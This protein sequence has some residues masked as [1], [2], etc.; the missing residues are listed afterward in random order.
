MHDQRA[1]RDRAARILGSWELLAF[2]AASANEVNPPHPDRIVP[3]AGIMVTEE[4]G[5]AR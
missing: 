5:G 1:A 2:Y 3:D 4:G